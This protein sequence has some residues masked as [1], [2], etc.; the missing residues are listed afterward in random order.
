MDRRARRNGCGRGSHASWAIFIILFGIALFLSNIGIFPIHNI[1]SY[2][3]LYLVFLG[4][5][6]LIAGAPQERASGLVLTAVGTVIFA[7][8]QHWLHFSGRQWTSVAGLILV[9]FGVMSLQAAR[10]GGPP[11]FRPRIARRYAQQFTPFN[12]AQPF[13][14]GQGDEWLRDSAVFGGVKR[15]VDTNRFAG[16]EIEAIFGSLDLDMRSITMPPLQSAATLHVNSVFGAVKLRVPQHWRVSVQVASAFGAAEDKTIPIPRTD[17][18]PSTLIVT[19]SS[20][21]GAVEI[22]N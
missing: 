16:G 8:N 18:P 5:S 14:S 6:R 3:P 15:R 13:T 7:S 1:W 17:L 11:F 20:A 19:G 10:G 2:W 12:P 4:V 21:F 9:V 22:D